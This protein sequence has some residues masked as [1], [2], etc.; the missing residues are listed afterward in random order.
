[1]LKKIICI[2]S[3][4][5]S[6]IA[7]ITISFAV[8][9]I[10]SEMGLAIQWN[11]LHNLRLNEVLPVIGSLFSIIFNLYGI[12]ILML[13]ISLIGLTIPRKKRINEGLDK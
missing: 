4:V 11:Q 12:P 10:L 13:L 5:I 6:I 7:I 8:N 2:T 9:Y 1:M 3:L